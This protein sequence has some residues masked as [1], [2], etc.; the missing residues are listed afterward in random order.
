MALLAGS[1]ADAGAGD[2]G[3]EADAEGLRG[4]VRLIAGAGGVERNGEAVVAPVVFLGVVDGEPEGVL[5]DLTRLVFGE[6]EGEDDEFG[7]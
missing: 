6:D 7:C 1:V 5:A 3:A 4:E 2:E